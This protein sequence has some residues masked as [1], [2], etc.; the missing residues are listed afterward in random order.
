MKI[1]EFIEQMDRRGMDLIQLKQPGAFAEYLK[2]TR[3]T[4]CGRHAIAV[5]LHAVSDATA[6]VDVSFL[7]YAQSSAAVSQR[8]SSVSYAAAK[9]T[10]AG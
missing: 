1:H 10:V 4:I 5:W 2:E 9:A 3:N 8:D 7:R 6:S